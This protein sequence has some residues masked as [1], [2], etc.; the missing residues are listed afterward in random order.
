MVYKEIKS[1]IYQIISA[2]LAFILMLFS[3]IWIL[4]GMV[5]FLQKINGTP[6]STTLP[7][8]HYISQKVINLQPFSAFHWINKKLC[9]KNVNALDTKKY[10]F[11]IFLTL[12]DQQLLTQLPENIHN[13]YGWKKRKLKLI[14]KKITYL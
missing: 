7:F 14:K 12:I 11:L 5:P 1:S 9:S 10:I 4:T 6:L 2:S 8:I 3:V 13:I